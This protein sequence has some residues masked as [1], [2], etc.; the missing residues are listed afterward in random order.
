MTRTAFIL[1]FFIIALAANAD[2]IDEWVSFTESGV[3]ATYEAATIE[4]VAQDGDSVLIEMTLDG[5]NV[6]SR[7]ERLL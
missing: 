1:T 5:M 7:K 4:V 2:A 3:S 6:Q